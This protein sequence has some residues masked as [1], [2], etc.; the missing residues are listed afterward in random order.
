MVILTTSTSPQSFK[1]IPR[2]KTYDGLY[3]TDESTNV[4]TQI[5]IS[6][7]ATN[8]YYETITATFVVASPS[9]TLKEGRFYTFEV[10][11][12]STVVYKGKIFCTDQTVSSYSVNHNTY[13]QHSTT[14]D[15][16]MYE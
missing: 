1:F 15:F 9:F 14:N 7:N 3:L 4:T 10:R 8:D 5:T 12:G 11:N 6:S 2:S 13:T 16:I